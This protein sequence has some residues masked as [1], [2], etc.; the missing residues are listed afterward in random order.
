MLS[1]TVGDF[2]QPA[3]STADITF[4]VKY[5]VKMP[6]S[7]AVS[8]T[9]IHTIPITFCL[10]V[11]P[12]PVSLSSYPSFPAAFPCCSLACNNHS[13]RRCSEW[14]TVTPSTVSVTGTLPSA[15]PAGDCV[16]MAFP[17]IT[18]DGQRS[19]TIL[20]LEP[21]NYFV[22]MPATGPNGYTAVDNVV[23]CVQLSAFSSPHTGCGIEFAKGTW[24]AWSF[25][26]VALID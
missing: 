2:E 9:G 16:V 17:A 23:S 4:N 25:D 11:S 26:C 14:Y 5:T 8:V 24:R 13:S 19:T 22:V 3:L 1:T 6:T 12:S 21:N 18:F 10:F 20:D 15:T 7:E